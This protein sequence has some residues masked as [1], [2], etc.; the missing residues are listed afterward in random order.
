MPYIQATERPLLWAVLVS[1][2]VAASGLTEIGGLTITGE[3]K[4]LV[5][6]PDENAFLGA[7]AGKAGDYAPLPAD[8]WLEAGAIYGYGGGLVIVRQSHN[9]TS[10]APEDTPA[11]FSVYRA[12]QTGAL[13]WVANERVEVG[14]QRTYAGKTWRAIQAHVTQADWTPDVTPALWAEV[15]PE[16][17]VGEWRSGSGIYAVGD[18][19]TYDGNLYECIQNPGVNIWTPPTV[20]ALWRLIGPA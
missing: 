2:E 3:D 20:P 14:T 13:A 11:L 5:S 16:P 7:V 19:C 15:V 18:R 6:D 1:D 12:E 17:P 10:Y 9:R 4:A 8:G